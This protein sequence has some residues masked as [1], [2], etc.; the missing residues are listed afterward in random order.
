M[1]TFLPFVIFKSIAP[2]PSF[3][4]FFSSYIQ[5]PDMQFLSREAPAM[6]LIRGLIIYKRQ[7]L[8]G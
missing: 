2:R 8:A 7:K 6:N 4:S 5:L 1:Q 3:V